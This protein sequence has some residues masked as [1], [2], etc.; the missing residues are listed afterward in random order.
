MKI[1]VQGLENAD[2]LLGGLGPTF[3]E[4]GSVART[5]AVFG[6]KFIQ[7]NLDRRRQ[8]LCQ[9]ING[10]MQKKIGK[11]FILS[12]V[13][14]HL[15]EVFFNFYADIVCVFTQEVQKIGVGQAQAPVHQPAQNPGVKCGEKIWPLIFCRQ[16]GQIWA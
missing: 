2:D 12:D 7:F 8:I 15:S 6:Q 4:Q 16:A 13:L 10:H 14:C 5:A 3:D 1:S 11:I 9:I